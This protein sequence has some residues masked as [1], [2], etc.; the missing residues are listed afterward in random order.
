MVAICCLYEERFDPQKRDRPARTNL[1]RNRAPLMNALCGFACA[2]Q[3]HRRFRRKTVL[4]DPAIS[5]SFGNHNVSSRGTMHV[6]SRQTLAIL[7]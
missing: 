1:R 7:I 6:I 5:V 2:S 4:R 3:Y